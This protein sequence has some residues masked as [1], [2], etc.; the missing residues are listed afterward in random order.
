VKKDRAI[1]DILKTEF[2]AIKQ[3]DQ[4]RGDSLF[5]VLAHTGLERETIIIQKN[6][7]QDKVL[8]RFSNLAAAEARRDDLPGLQQFEA[9]AKTLADF[10]SDP[11][12]PQEYR[13]DLLADDQS[14]IY[15]KSTL[16][17]E[18][19]QHWLR[20]VTLYKKLEQ[21]PRTA[22][23][24]EKK[25]AEITKLIEDELGVNQDDSSKQNPA[26]PDG[27]SLFGK[28]TEIT[29]PLESVLRRKQAGPSKQN[30][31]KLQQEYTRFAVTVRD[32]NNLLALPAI[33]KNKGKI[34]TNICNDLWKKLQAHETAIKLIIKP[35]Y[36]KYLELMEGKVQ[37]LVFAKTTEIGKNFE[38]LNINQ[39]QSSTEKKTP[40]EAVTKFVKGTAENILSLSK[41]GELLNKTV[42]VTGWDEIRQSVK[43]KQIKWLDFFETI[44]LNNAKKCRLAKIYRIKK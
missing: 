36:C 21:D 10:V 18:D 20:E 32:V 42:E 1:R 26:K 39:L 33:E 25:I 44:D 19:F 8:I 16:M 31:A 11:D 22:H 38:P 2:E 9:L 7:S 37:R 34:D 17:A 3:A 12:W 28:I 27:S 41:L 40:I 4:I 23:P 43:D 14:Q 29:R 6:S 35:E 30:L 5:T 24:W 15:N 13:A